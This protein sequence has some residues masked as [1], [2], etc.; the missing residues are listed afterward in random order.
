MPEAKAMIFSTA[1]ATYDTYQR[2]VDRFCDHYMAVN[3][4]NNA[5]ILRR[6]K[7][8]R[9]IMGAFAALPACLLLAALGY[10][11]TALGIWTVRVL[12]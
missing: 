7:H 9:I 12:R 11:L 8:S 2:E 4:S 10:Y 3:L 6:A 5:L 1:E